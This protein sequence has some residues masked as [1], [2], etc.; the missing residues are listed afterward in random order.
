MMS[1][2]DLEDT[3]DDIG[4][5]GSIQSDEIEIESGNGDQDRDDEYKEDR[6][7]SDPLDSQSASE[8]EGDISDTSDRETSG[9]NSEE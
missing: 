2:S 1:V 6:N 4:D 5:Y 9:D 8:F 7:D 3:S